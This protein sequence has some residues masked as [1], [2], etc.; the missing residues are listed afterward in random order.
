MPLK[1]LYHILSDRRLERSPSFPDRH[2]FPLP[3]ALR[4]AQT[5]SSGY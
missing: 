5:A 4:G 2:L 1:A 3:P